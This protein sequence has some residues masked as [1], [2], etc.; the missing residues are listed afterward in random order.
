M[1]YVSDLA[2]YVHYIQFIRNSLTSGSQDM[3]FLSLKC[4]C[5]FCFSRNRHDLK[6]ILLQLSST[7]FFFLR[8]QGMTVYDLKNFGDPYLGTRRLERSEIL[9]LLISRKVKQVGK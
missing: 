1:H 3:D 9:Y 8:V 5:L 6:T 2:Q 4:L 7:L